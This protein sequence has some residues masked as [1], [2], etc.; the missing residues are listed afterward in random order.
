MT[1]WNGVDIIKVGMRL[2]ATYQGTFYPRIIVGYVSDRFFLGVPQGEDAEI[3][4]PTPS[5]QFEVVTE[6]QETI[7][8]M[9]DVTGASAPPF[10]EAFNALYSAGYRKV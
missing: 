7:Q 4:G 2:S 5:F 3:M 9:R 8:D 6:R 1:D 10:I